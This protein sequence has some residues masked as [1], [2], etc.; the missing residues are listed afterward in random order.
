MVSL[1]IAGYFDFRAVHTH[2]VWW[3]ITPL[4]ITLDTHF[5]W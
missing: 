3:E 1:E 5:V 4:L 2:F